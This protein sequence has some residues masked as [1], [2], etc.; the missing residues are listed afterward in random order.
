M[1]LPECP[2]S[3]CHASSP[4]AS[5]LP[6]DWFMAT[7]VGSLKT[8]PSPWRYTSVFAV[9]RSNARSRPISRPSR[10][11]GRRSLGASRTH[12]PRGL[13]R[14]EVLFLPDRDVLFQPLDELAA[15]LERLG[16]VRG[17]DGDRD[18]RL[19]HRELSV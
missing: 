15:R 17:A 9:P 12:H 10:G 11:V 18:A 2:P 6:V 1:T 16:A 4:I 8:I 13:A 3:S 5:T 7:T 19:A 14:G